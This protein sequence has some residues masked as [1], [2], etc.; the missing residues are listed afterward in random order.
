M[1]GALKQLSVHPMS[2]LKLGSLTRRLASIFMSLALLVMAHHAWADIKVANQILGKST[3]DDGTALPSKSF[4]IQKGVTDYSGGEALWI[5]GPIVAN[6]KGSATLFYDANKRLVAAYIWSDS[7]NELLKRL[8]RTAHAKPRKDKSFTSGDW[9]MRIGDSGEK[10][11][12]AISTP[13]FDAQLREDIQRRVEKERGQRQ[14]LILLASIIASAI[15]T[16]FIYLIFRMRRKNKGWA[17][18]NTTMYLEKKAMDSV[19]SSQTASLAS[20]STA[21]AILA[22]TNNTSHATAFEEETTYYIPNNQQNVIATYDHSVHD[23]LLD[24]TSSSDTYDYWEPATNCANG[25]PMHNG[26][27]I[28]G[29]SFGSNFNDPW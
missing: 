5:T 18:Q 11:F 26:V 14:L 1:W 7:L 8:A 2:F 27:D 10:K 13:S 4:S 24:T 9:H 22:T 6:M 21:A 16:Y 15:A 25:M 19:K 12:I 20:V 29:N 28:Y 17:P 23:S 3:I